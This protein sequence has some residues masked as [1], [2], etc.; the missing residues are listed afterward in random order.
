MPTRTACRRRHRRQLVIHDPAARVEFDHDGRRQS[1]GLIDL[2]PSG[3][4]F[5]AEADRMPPL[6]SGGKLSP[7]EVRVGG[8]TIQGEL[9]VMHVTRSGTAHA[10]C[11][12]LFYPA[13]DDDLVKLKALVAGLEA[14]RP[15]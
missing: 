13:T 6:E 5:A 4:S 1:F 2:S 3:L 7:V 9:V 11:G 8:C 12:A 14:A 15:A 10:Q